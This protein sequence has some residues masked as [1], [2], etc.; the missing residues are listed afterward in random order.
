M[1]KEEHQETPIYPKCCMGARWD[2]IYHDGKYQL[3]C[4]K[5]G[6]PDP[7]IIINGPPQEEKCPLCKEKKKKK[8]GL[9]S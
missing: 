4:H 6:R 8:E 3:V 9:L 5:C 2:V 7:V 1:S